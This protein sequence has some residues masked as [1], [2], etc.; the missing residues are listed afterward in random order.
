VVVRYKQKGARQPD[1]LDRLCKDP[2]LKRT[3]VGGDIRQFRHVK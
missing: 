3:D 2:W 1:L